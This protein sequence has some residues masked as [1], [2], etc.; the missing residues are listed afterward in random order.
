MG[1][2]IAAGDPGLAAAD[3]LCRAC[4]DLLGVDGAAVSIVADGVMRGTFGASNELS[5]RLDEYQFTFGEGPCLDSV[6]T[7]RP[8]LVGDLQDPEETRWP[9]YADA[10]LGAGVR[11]VYALP[12]PFADA[13]IGALDLYR[14]APCMLGG[15][16]LA[17]GVL[18]AELVAGPL[19][20]LMTAQTA[21]D[22]SRGDE[23]EEAQA[24]LGPLN[25]LE[26]HQATGMV[27]AQLDVGPEEALVRLRAHAFA[28]GLTAA[29][30]ARRI[31]ARQLSLAEDPPGPGA[32][33]GGSS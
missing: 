30:T 6:R 4:V 2:A 24:L 33:P 23:F 7:A 15:E 27:M 19:V 22:G 12:V 13:H 8:V 3:R 20:D 11:A 28:Y 21:T 5:R 16:A 14:I 10:V 18:A 25:R 17:G 1:A 9:A 29:E 26:I 31:V 32:A